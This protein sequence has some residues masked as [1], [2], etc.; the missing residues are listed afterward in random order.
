MSKLLNNGNLPWNSIECSWMSS[1]RIWTDI[2][3]IKKTDN[4]SNHSIPLEV[5]VRT[6]SLLFVQCMRNIHVLR[7][8]W[9]DKLDI[10]TE[11]IERWNAAENS[12]ANQQLE[13]G[14]DFIMRVRFFSRATTI[15]AIFYGIFHRLAQCNSRG[16]H[17]RFISRRHL[18]V[19]GA[20]GYCL[21]DHWYAEVSEDHWRWYRSLICGCSTICRYKAVI[22][23]SAVVGIALF[24]FMLWTSTLFGL[25]LAQVC[26]GS[27]MAA[28]VAYYTYIYAKVER[29]KYQLVT[30]Q[31]R[32][33]ILAGRFLGS[34]VAQAVVSYNLMDYRQLNYLSLGCKM[35]LAR[36]L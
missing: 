34:T 7:V 13:M 28:E 24:S 22:V 12:A 14:G 30:S 3:A 18:L 36:I 15:R 19:F 9:P 16:Y 4:K 32:S 20:I 10:E 11:S 6:T 5:I 31:T 26:Y 2:Q 23:Y 35:D 33:A 17:T 27:F 8:I 29:G 21:S 1:R 25:L